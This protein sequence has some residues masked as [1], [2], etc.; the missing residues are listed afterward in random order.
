MKGRKIALPKES[1]KDEPR[2][3][4]KESTLWKFKGRKDK[5]NGLYYVKIQNCFTG[6]YMYINY[7]CKRDDYSYYIYMTPDETKATEFTVNKK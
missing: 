4:E 1:A 2:L 6:E 7:E 3:S 5:D